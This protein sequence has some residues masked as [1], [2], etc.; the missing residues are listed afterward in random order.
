M[1]V[2]QLIDIHKRKYKEQI[3]YNLKFQCLNIVVWGC[4]KYTWCE[5]EKHVWNHKITVIFRM[6]ITD[7]H[8]VCFLK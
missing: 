2:S 3:K 4:C 7:V 8:G 6:A 5:E 1:L